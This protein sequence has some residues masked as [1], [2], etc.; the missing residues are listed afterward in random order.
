MSNILL[1]VVL[2][3]AVAAG[4]LPLSTVTASA[5]TQALSR[6]RFDMLVRSDFFAGFAGDRERLARAM[7][8]C[9]RYLAENPAHAEALVWHG[10]GLLFQAGRRLRAG[11]APEWRDACGPPDSRR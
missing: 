5:Q 9:E 8:T 3:L 11:R 10:S 1:T 2:N 6:P 7:A 4:P